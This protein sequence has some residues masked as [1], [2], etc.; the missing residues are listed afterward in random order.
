M[1][2]THSVCS[3]VLGLHTCSKAEVDVAQT[4]QQAAR[5]TV[6]AA[7]KQL[8]ALK[9]EVDG[10]ATACKT[11][12]ALATEARD[13]V[14]ELE[15]KKA[16]L[17]TSLAD[18]G[19]QP[20][21]RAAR[22]FTSR[23]WCVQANAKK[24]ALTASHSSNKVEFPVGLVCFPLELTSTST[25]PAGTWHKQTPHASPHQAGRNV[26][27]QTARQGRCVARVQ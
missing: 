19:S 8:A 13:A 12:Q 7:A 21:C 18:V 2:Y 17:Q 15:A 26:E 25:A 16:H 24:A 14:R 23:A 10:I 22:R 9:L 4:Q 3:Q 27:G 6:D 20:P 11:Q 5:L 1:V